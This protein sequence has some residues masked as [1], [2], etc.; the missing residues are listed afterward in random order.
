MTEGASGE[1]ISVAVEQATTSNNWTWSLLVWAY[2]DWMTG[3]I[4]TIVILILLYLCF[5][6]DLFPIFLG[7]SGSDDDSGS[8]GGGDFGGGGASSDF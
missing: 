7:G 6:F 3:T 8:S 4:A 2:S 5:R 1:E